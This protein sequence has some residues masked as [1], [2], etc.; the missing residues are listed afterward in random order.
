M[1]LPSLIIAALLACDTPDPF[2]A[3]AD[4]YVSA[5]T[6]LMQQ[7]EQL[8]RR[9]LDLAGT[10]MQKG[11]TA[12]DVARTL[13][14]DVLPASAAL[15]EQARAVTT[16]DPGL[17]AAHQELAGAWQARDAAWRGV[18]S[19][20]TSQDLDALDRALRE[21]EQ[22]RAAEERYIFDANAVLRPYGHQ[23]VRYP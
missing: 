15:L 12:D 23:I 14:A 22:A 20:W 2:V 13:Q 17:L 4:A 7:N 6:P 21:R 9:F 5:V 8:E 10:L 11:A 19:A 1:V 3:Q 16:P 18:A